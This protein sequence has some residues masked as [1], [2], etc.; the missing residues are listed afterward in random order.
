MIRLR[1]SRVAFGSRLCRFL[2]A[3]IIFVMSQ[4]A[5][6]SKEDADRPLVAIISATDL[7]WEA[8]VLTAALSSLESLQLL[9]REQISRILKEHGISLS[10]PGKSGVETGKL[11]GADGL[12]I[13]EKCKPND[14]DVLVA[15]FVAVEQGVALACVYAELPVENLEKWSSGIKKRVLP[16]APKFKVLKKDAVP[17]SI[18]NIRAPVG[19]AAAE[20]LEQQLT[21]L[22]AHRLMKEKDLFVLERRRM[23]ALAWETELRADA[24]NAFWTGS[25]MIDGSCSFDS[26]G[27]GVKVSLN[28]KKSDWTVI[29]IAEVGSANDLPGII[30]RLT[31]KILVKL[32]KTQCEIPWGECDEA[33]Q[34]FQEAQWA[35]NAGL[36]DVA[37]SA[38]ESAVALGGHGQDLLAARM[39]AYSSRALSRVASEGYMNYKLKNPGSAGVT[40]DAAITA[41][42]L[43]FDYL[44]A[45]SV[46][47]PA[48]R[49]SSDYLGPVLLESASCV[50]AGCYKAN[51]VATQQEKLARLRELLRANSSAM[52]AAKT[53]NMFFVWKVIDT[54]TY[55]GG[56]WH[57]TVE[58]SAC[59]YEK[60]LKAYPGDDHYQCESRRHVKYSMF[61]HRSNRS[62]S[63]PMAVDW[64]TGKDETSAVVKKLISALSSSKKVEYM[65]NVMLLKVL[66]SGG[67][68]DGKDFDESVSVLL[69]IA[70]QMAK[71]DLGNDDCAGLIEYL[72]SS[73]NSKSVLLQLAG[74]LIGKDAS[75]KALGSCFVFESVKRVSPRLTEDEAVALFDAVETKLKQGGADNHAIQSML[76]DQHPQWDLARRR[77]VKAAEN[78]EIA[79][80]DVT[81]YWRPDLKKAV[82]EGSGANRPKEEIWPNSRNGMS[83]YEGSQVVRYEGGELWC[84]INRDTSVLFHLNPND[85][86]VIETIIIPD[87]PRLATS[88]ADNASCS[89]ASYNISDRDVLVS[90]ETILLPGRDHFVR[91]DRKQKKIIYFDLPKAYYRKAAMVGHFLFMGN[92]AEVYGGIIEQLDLRTGEK[93]TIANSRRKP[94]EGPLDDVPPYY[95]RSVIPLTGDSVMFLVYDKDDSEVSYV[96]SAGDKKWEKLYSSRRHGMALKT[97]DG[98][99]FCNHEGFAYFDPASKKTSYLLKSSWTTDG[100]RKWRWSIKENVVPVYHGN[101]E[102]A[103]YENN[104]LSVLCRRVKETGWNHSIFT[105]NDA[106][107]PAGVLIPLVLKYEN[108]DCNIDL[109]WQGRILHVPAGIIIWDAHMAGFWFA[110]EKDIKGYAESR[111]I[112]RDTQSVAGE[113]LT[114]D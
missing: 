91:Y 84:L 56:L 74:I 39:R 37:I 16:L 4:A 61:K 98:V 73:E 64:R 43:L 77:G 63:Y 54:A 3:T 92:V 106:T 13:L 45:N 76:L 109:G 9:E 60:M 14:K 28:I 68:R 103:F 31:S 42:D 59:Y 67:I 75:P 97:S 1:G 50:I 58:D 80:V 82:M 102:S 93:V 113:S 107:A 48:S 70:E 21:L 26:G 17:I 22:L 65:L 25:Y 2:S 11:L 52:L 10:T 78:R 40:L 23:E 62:P 24:T 34:Y 46:D 87:K 81:Y 47:I 49:G 32:G 41:Q 71:G 101:T 18:L 99:L 29:D 108:S 20:Q 27:K 12:I 105:I 96:Y 83:S 90:D 33:T 30:E 53:K 5:A 8:D 86:T 110:S 51:V 57:D 38:S 88:G 6:F 69:A 112:T 85:F 72:G 35:L 89:R 44:K 114:E 79:Q 104:N 100:K 95:V 7:G 94:K 36:Y 111:K 66:Q 19:G 15:R 55:W